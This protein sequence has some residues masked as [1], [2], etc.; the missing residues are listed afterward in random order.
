M[1]SIIEENRVGNIYTPYYASPEYLKRRNLTS[2]SDVYSVGV[3]AFNLAVF[4]DE[5]QLPNFNRQEFEQV[6]C[7]AGGQKMDQFS[8]K[9]MFIKTV[10]NNETFSPILFGMLQKKSENRISAVDASKSNVF[11]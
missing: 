5:I 3:V 1:D 6:M 9:N 2:K 11:I 10:F 7:T 4:C 8:R